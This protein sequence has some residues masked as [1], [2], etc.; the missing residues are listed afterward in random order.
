MSD[1][2]SAL[3]P[4]LRL[5][6]VVSAGWISAAVSALAELGIADHLDTPRTAADLAARAGA[7]ADGLS[8]FLYAAAAAGVL[9]A[10]PDGTFSLTEVGE[11]LRT[12]HPEGMREMCRLTGMEEFARAWAKAAHTA[13]TGEPAF[14]AAYG[15]PLFAHMS[16]PDHADFSGVFHRAMA[17]SAAGRSVGSR[18]AFPEGARVVDI[19]GGR[20]AMIAGLLTAHPHLTGT[21]FDLPNAVRGADKLLADAGVAGRAT[22]VAGS[23]FDEVPA[24]GDVYLLSRVIGNWNDEDSV[25]ILRR[26]RAAM[27]PGSRLVVVGHMPTDEDRTHYVRA[28]DLYMFVLLQAR[29]RTPEQYR[30]LFARADLE[31]SYSDLRPDEE[32]LIEARPV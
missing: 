24:G 29:L 5:I 30:E 17:E 15:R 28:L 31:L 19:G 25:R 23:F 12:G 9:D 4:R 7:D 3:P 16:D 21:V 18:Y 32:C 20:G 26:V 14:D 13:R 8:R 2:R 10:H 6:E 27:H 11:V 22:V 1:S